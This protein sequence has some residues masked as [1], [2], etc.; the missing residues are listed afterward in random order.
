[1]V[2]EFGPPSRWTSATKDASAPAKGIEILGKVD[3]SGYEV[4]TKGKVSIQV[5]LAF[6]A[7][8][9]LFETH[10]LSSNP[11]VTLDLVSGA[12]HALVCFQCMEEGWVDWT[13]ESE[14]KTNRPVVDA[15]LGMHLLKHPK[16]Q[17]LN[18]KLVLGMHL[19]KHPQPQTPNPK[20]VLGMH[21]LKHPKPQTPNPK[22]VLGMHLLKHRLT[23]SNRCTQNA[24]T[25]IY[26]SLL[27]A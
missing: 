6:R 4:R 14:A 18:P 20:L 19:L 17:T 15:V 13:Q 8:L 24:K 16:P 26:H 1:V 7:D 10:S 27:H 25:I 22:L 3:R 11:D 9:F 2:V 21:L 5:V 23:R 12:P